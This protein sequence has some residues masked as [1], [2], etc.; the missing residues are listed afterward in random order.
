MVPTNKRWA[1]RRG[2]RA[3]IVSMKVIRGTTVWTEENGK[4]TV[5]VIQCSPKHEHTWRLCLSED[6]QQRQFRCIEPT[7]DKR[8]Q[9]SN[10]E[11]NKIR[12]EIQVLRTAC[13]HTCANSIRIY[14]KIKRS[15]KFERRYRREYIGQNCV[16][17]FGVTVPRQQTIRNTDA[18]C[19]QRHQL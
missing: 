5:Y 16:K 11:Q 10:K 13:F 1:N 7:D 15:R 4:T 2:N 12:S 6:T 19:S 3:V 17:M 14:S 8:K 9:E 18:T